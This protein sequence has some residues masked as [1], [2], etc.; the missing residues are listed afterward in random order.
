MTRGVVVNIASDVGV[1]SPD[2]RIYHDL[3]RDELFNTPIAYA[4]TKAAIFRASF[5]PPTTSICLTKLANSL[6]ILRAKMQITGR[7]P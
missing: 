6:V 4:T 2:H 5:S 1:I 3:P 7:S